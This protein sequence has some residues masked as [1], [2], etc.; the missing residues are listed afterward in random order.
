MKRILIVDDEAI[1]RQLLSRYL[2][3]E[4]FLTVEASS[5][6]EALALWQKEPKGMDCIISDMKMEPMDGRAFFEALRQQ[7]FSGPFFL[8]TAFGNLEDAVD[9]MQRGVRDYLTKPLNLNELVLK[10]RRALEEESVKEENASLRREVFA[11]QSGTPL[12]TK[13]PRMQEILAMIPSV[14]M[15]EVPVVIFGESGTG[16]ELV[17]QAIHQNSPRKKGPFVPLNCAAL[18]PGVLE[19]ELFGHE[20]GAFTGAS[21]TAIGRIEMAD[22]GTLFLD[23]IGDMPQEIQ[24]KLLRV[25]QEG[26]IQRVGSGQS[27]NINFRLIS[28]THKDL[29]KEVAEHRFRED[30]FYRLC[31][32]PLH[33]PPLRQRQADIPFLAQHFADQFAK[34]IQRPTKTFTPQAVASLLAHPFSGNVRELI[35]VV[36]RSFIFS[37][38][39]TIDQIHGLDV[40]SAIPSGDLLSDLMSRTLP[41][42]VELLERSMITRALQRSAGVQTKAAEVLGIQER[43]LRY[44]MGK[45][46]MKTK[47]MKEN[48]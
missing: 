33:L 28:A 20:K 6:K 12:L 31:V 44:K 24:V 19:S 2:Y 17:A 26:V 8:M 22:G 25:I 4:G 1:Q 36:Q 23:E 5:G 38:G 46:G 13:D 32:V 30:F 40:K 3:K 15:S 42:A 10:V 37:S 9:M 14:A 39:G 47:D 7:H 27:R 41:E 48:L 11:R 45:W 43:V 34:Q 35:N 16:K 21:R 18:N 29:G